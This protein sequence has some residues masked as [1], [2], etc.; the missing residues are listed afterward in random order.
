MNYPKLKLAFA[1]GCC[2]IIAFILT[3]G[4]LH[5]QI[6]NTS[7]KGR[8]SISVL[9]V[10]YNSG[11]PIPSSI[12]KKYKIPQRFDINDIGIKTL[13]VDAS[14][15]EQAGI[16][17]EILD[18]LKKDKIPNNIIRSILIDEQLGYMTPQVLEDRGLYSATDADVITAKNAAVGL[19]ILKSRGPELLNNI[20]FAVVQPT[21]YLSTKEEYIY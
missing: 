8:N 19:D 3:A 15:N 20:Y 6:E 17:T 13:D 11:N 4:Q 2:T 5:A 12:Y 14:F 16:N 21:N 1:K 7:P 18:A 10:D 9:F